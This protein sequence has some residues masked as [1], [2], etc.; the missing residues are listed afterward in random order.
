[1]LLR[2]RGNLLLMY[3]IGRINVGRS[4]IDLSIRGVGTGIIGSIAINW[5][6]PCLW[7]VDVA[8]I[9]GSGMILLGIPIAVWVVVWVSHVRL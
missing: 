5:R 6:L 2:R 3:A 7:R 1:M 8:V 9:L 4:G